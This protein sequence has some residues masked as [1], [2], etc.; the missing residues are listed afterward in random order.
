LRGV[1]QPSTKGIVKTNASLSAGSSLLSLALCLFAGSPLDCR[2]TPLTATAAVQTLPDPAAPIVTYLKAGSEPV[3]PA[4]DT[5]VGAPP[6]WMA[7]DLPGPFEAYVLDKDLTKGL[8]VKPGSSI[9]L[10]PKP[11]AGVLEIAASGDKFEIT[12]LY[13]KWTQVHF[14]KHLVGYIQT[15]PSPASVPMATPVASAA[16]TPLP[17]SVLG[18]PAPTGEDA[19]IPRSL[20]GTF[21]STRHAFAPHRPYDWAIVDE[22]GSRL[23]YLD[24][25]KLLLTDQPESYVGKS[26][27]VTGPMSTVSSGKD[28]VITVE[29]LQLK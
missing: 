2:A 21:A 14:D 26:V 11:D 19:A 29:G 25:S 28:I 15:I 24:L 22:S 7:V 10:A 4:G 18:Q 6:G 23:A 13:G 12:G 5:A 17:A 27:V 20:E 9:Y 8:E 1:K 3:P 16:S